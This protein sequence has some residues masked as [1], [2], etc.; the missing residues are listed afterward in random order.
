MNRSAPEGAG[1]SPE[2]HAAPRRAGRLAAA[3]LALATVFGAERGTATAT[4][5]P[6]HGPTP[7][8][9]ATKS[10]ERSL[11]P[12]APLD[13]W[14]AHCDESLSSVIMYFPFAKPTSLEGVGTPEEGARAV[15]QLIEKVEQVN[16]TFLFQVYEEVEGDPSARDAFAARSPRTAAVARMIEYGRTRDA[17]RAAFGEYRLMLDEVAAGRMTPALAWDTASSP[18]VFAAFAD[19]TAAASASGRSST[20]PAL[21]AMLAQAAARD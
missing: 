15:A 4:P 13:V 20:H 21:V 7:K 5:A 11:A 2:R 19:R 10:A 18:S 16:P 8:P 9:V 3:A 12:G 6:A 1:A 17:R 14:L